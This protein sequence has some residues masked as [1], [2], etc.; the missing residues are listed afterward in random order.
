MQ[1]EQKLRVDSAPFDIVYSIRKA[2]QSG[3]KQT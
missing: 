2:I 3:G 1:E